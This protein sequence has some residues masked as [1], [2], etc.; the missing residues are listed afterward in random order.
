[1]S[2]HTLTHDFDAVHDR[3]GTY[4]TQWDYIQD[5]FGRPGILP[6]SISD[7]D[8]TAPE[9]IVRRVTEVAASGLYGYTR[10]NHHDYKGSITGWYERRFAAT[11]SE[12]W[13]VYSPSVMYAVSLLVRLLTKPGDGV[14]TL[15]PMYDSFP[16]TIEGNGRRLVKSALR[17]SEGD[18]SY[19][20]DFDELDRLAEECSA[21]LLC[22]PHNPTGR[23]WS[24][25]EMAR[26]VEVCRAHGLYLIT[27]EIHMDISLGARTHVP[28]LSLLGSYE[29]ICTASSSTKVF[30]TPGLQGSYVIIPDAGLRDAFLNQTRHVD[31]LNSVAQLG[32]YASMVGYNEC[33]YYVDQLCDYVRGNMTRLEEFLRT[34][35]PEVRF[36]VPDGTYLAWIDVS[37]L[38]Y[39]SDELQDALVN[40]GGVGIMRGE[41]YGEAGAG[42]L[43]MCVG[44]PRIKLEDGLARMRR[45]IDWLRSGRPEEARA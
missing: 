18:P 2:E 43:R 20:I 30:N 12:D 35:Y 9:P 26:I 22:S 36:S 27:D 1:M 8:F 21:M 28:A 31:F 17:P 39:T 24:A 29:R 25:E 40:V 19:V 41:T 33:A 10:W 42:H 45:G 4:C 44:C 14:L 5:R 38:G 23:I 13:V 3:Y 32:M 34:T 15:D 16:G 7:T 11:L 37:G 6:F